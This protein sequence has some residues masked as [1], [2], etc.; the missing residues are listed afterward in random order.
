MK[1]TSAVIVALGGDTEVMKYLKSCG[2]PVSVKTVHAW[3]TRDSIPAVYWRALTARA[4][5][6][7]VPG[8][9]L[10]ALASMSETRRA[11]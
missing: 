8:V 5:K 4:R 10:E 7:H 3:K 11:S 9:T 1:S 2:W 6:L